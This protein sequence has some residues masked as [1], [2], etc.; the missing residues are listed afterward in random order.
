[1]AEHVLEGQDEYMA[2]FRTREGRK[3][4]ATS[5]KNQILQ[6]EKNLAGAGRMLGFTGAGLDRET[7]IGTT[8][9]AIGFG[10]WHEVK[11]FCPY[12][13]A[14]IPL[15]D[16]RLVVKDH[17]ITNT[18]DPIDAS[19]LLRQRSGVEVE[20]EED[21]DDKMGIVLDPAFETSTRARHAASA[22]VTHP[23]DHST[24]VVLPA[25]PLAPFAPPA[26]S[27]GLVAPLVGFSAPASTLTRPDNPTPGSGLRRKREDTRTLQKNLEG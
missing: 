4:D 19:R 26:G 13:Y 24:T 16:D 27:S 7:D 6:M 23:V 18:A 8:N 12:F 20:S 3:P 11:I 22:S 14:L 17:A 21:E 5:V 9:E 1:M 15:L 10:V 2:V 25:G